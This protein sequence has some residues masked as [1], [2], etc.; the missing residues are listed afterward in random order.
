MIKSIA[1]V[2]S[3]L[4]ISALCYAQKTKRK[5]QVVDDGKSLLWKI[6]GNGL[7]KPSYIFGT[8][9]IIC[10]DDYVWTPTMQYALKQSEQVVFEMDMDDPSL[11]AQ[12]TKGM[13]TKDGKKLKDYYTEEEYKRLNDVAVKNGIPL[14]MLQNIEPFGLISFLYMKASSCQIPD[15][16]EGN[17]M[18]LAQKDDKE[19]LGLESLDEQL[20][21]IDG[22]DND[23]IAKQVLK[24]VDDLDS[25]KIT[26][27]SM[28]TLYKKQDLPALHNLFLESPDY[29][30]DLDALLYSRNKK[31]VPI[32]SSLAEAKPTFFAVGAGHLWGQDGVIDLLQKSGYTL[33][34][35]K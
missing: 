9:H 31:W 27:Q 30:D 4:L 33:T 13:M 1:L 10:P 26:F 34:A 32:M 15:S 11:Q 28:L 29:K 5:E 3:A 23:S 12:M 6:T 18:K 7:T 17:I 16:Y 24:I 22:M 8:I 14:A 21:V 25:F 2:C 20:K 19:I 35:I